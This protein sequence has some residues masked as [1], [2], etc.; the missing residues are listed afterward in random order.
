MGAGAAEGAE[1]EDAGVGWDA[2]VWGA[3]VGGGDGD[4]REGVVVGVVRGCWG[5]WDGAARGVGVGGRG[6]VRARG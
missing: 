6:G 2:G 1:V 3:G 4:G 5:C